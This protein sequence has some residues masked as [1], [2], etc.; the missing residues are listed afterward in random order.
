MMK[1]EI[2]YPHNNYATLDEY[3]VRKNIKRIFL[4]KSKYFDSFKISS[5]FKTLK[6]R[7]GIETVSFNH[8]HPNPEYN[9]VVEGEKIFTESN[10]DCIFAIGGGSAID[11]AKCIKLYFRL[12]EKKNF[13]KQKPIPNNIPLIVLPT[14]A[15]TGSE[16]TRYAVIYYEG[17]KQS[18][19]NESII[20]S[21]VIFDSSA[22]ETLPDY[23]RKST[24][25]DAFCHAV[26]SFWSVNSTKE[27]KEFSKRAIHLILENYESYLKNEANGN[28]NM[29][30]AANIAGK[31]INITQTT[32]GHAMCYKLTSLYGISHGHAAAL[33]VSILWP[34]MIN[35]TDLCID[36][37]GKDYL[38]KNFFELASV[39][40]E[41]TPMLSAK[42]FAT[43]V[44]NLQLETPVIKSKDDFFVL[45]KSVN[46]VR[47]KNNPV[48]LDE[49]SI[50]MLYH[51]I[52]G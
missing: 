20:P 27:S 34:H 4:V 12:D 24:M 14:T 48:K 47:L 38:E 50:N 6:G 46:P 3:L 32:A 15:G 31:A 40:G 10:C 29:L 7:L 43:F 28:M 16:E 9:S 13:L 5:Y 25:L 36:L 39:M 8:Y 41:K 51:Q 2:L 44:R 30:M 1:Q 49:E 23:Q 21:V 18:I 35:N 42:K 19:T 11:V 37:R 17:E 33:C 22:L 52:L 45:K 26:E